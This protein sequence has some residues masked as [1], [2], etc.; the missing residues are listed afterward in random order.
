MTTAI[1]MMSLMGLIFGTHGE[2]MGVRT[3]DSSDMNRS[4]SIVIPIV[5]TCVGLPLILMI[6]YIIFRL[7]LGAYLRIIFT[8]EY[9]LVREVEIKAPIEKVFD[10]VTTARLWTNFYPETVAVGGVTDRPFVRGDVIIEKFMMMGYLYIVFNYTV[11][12]YNKP[13]G[14]VFS[15]PVY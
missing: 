10:V 7:P 12:Q 4:M 13:W 3:D 6:V 14:V 8:G 2:T 1:T 15:T 5:A 11:E 9:T